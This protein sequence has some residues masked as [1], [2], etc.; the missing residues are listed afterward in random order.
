MAIMKMGRARAV[1]GGG[2]GAP[3]VR[4]LRVAAAEDLRGPGEMSK[5]GTLL[6]HEA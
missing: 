4:R 2:T 3:E 1:S 6:K 5:F